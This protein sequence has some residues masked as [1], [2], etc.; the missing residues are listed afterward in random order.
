MSQRFLAAAIQLGASSDKDAN[1]ASAARLAR[2]AAERGAALIVLPEV[3]FWRGAREDEQAAAEPIPGPTTERLAALAAE[4]GVHLVGGSLLEAAPGTAKA[5]NTCTVFDPRGRLLATYRKLHL[6]DV[7]IPGHVC[8]RE[9]DTRAPGG[10]PVTVATEL[11]R[12]DQAK[13]FYEEALKHAPDDATAYTNLGSVLGRQGQHD[14]ALAHHRKALQLNPRFMKA[15]Y[16]IGNLLV[17]LG[18]HEEAIAH[19][20]AAAELSPGDI[21]ILLPLSS[22]L[23]ETGDLAG[24][25]VRLEQAIEADPTHP[26]LH[27]DLGIVLTELGETRE[28]ID[29]LERSLEVGVAEAAGPLHTVIGTLLDEIDEH[30]RAIAHYRK[31]IELSPDEPDGYYNL[32]V[33]LTAVGKR[34]EAADAY[35][36]V[37]ALE[38]G[39]AEGL[40]NLGAAL[41]AEGRPAEAVPYFERALVAAPDDIDTRQNLAAAL[42]A[43]GRP[44]D[45]VPVLE[46]ALDA[47]TVTPSMLN[48][49]AWVRATSP[50]ASLRD[51]AAAVR[52]A[53]VACALTEDA[54]PQYL[55]TLAAAYAEAGRFADAERVARRA[56]EVAGRDGD[57]ETAAT[58]RARLTLYAAGR[59]Y[60]E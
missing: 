2:T 60:R 58:L 57:E 51:G 21:G 43:A 9:S 56:I 32:G 17:E 11:G 44:A 54:N 22:A 23:T 47:E 28:A 27:Y 25:R 34:E 26:T 1:F 55:D 3:F 38:P 53:E 4:L 42:Y 49:L 29:H 39:H 37:V 8:V 19:F 52:F 50:D 16:N 45:A 40:N 18:R 6:F 41:V 15:H 14:E 24:A 35:R 12:L 36:R 48:L 5:Y 46:V 7:D 31:A 20:E 10:E 30:E 59:P 33:A 13:E